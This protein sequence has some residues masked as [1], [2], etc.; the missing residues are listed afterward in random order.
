MPRRKTTEIPGLRNRLR[1]AF[2]AIADL[3]G[4]TQAQIAGDLGIGRTAITAIL[5]GT[6]K[7]PSRQTLMLLESVFGYRQEWLLTGQGEPQVYY[8]EETLFQNGIVFYR[9]GFQRRF[10]AN[11]EGRHRILAQWL[12]AVVQYDGEGGPWYHAAWDAK[13]VAEPTGEL[14]SF[15]VGIAAAEQPG[16]FVLVLR[17]PE[18]LLHLVVA[19]EPEETP[20]PWL[21]GEKIDRLLYV[22]GLFDGAWRQIPLRLGARV[23]SLP[24]L[25]VN[26]REYKQMLKGPYPKG[27]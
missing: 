13:D 17:Q 20:I 16:H 24:A 2:R 4:K 8:G 5:N 11:R 18:A 10:Y 12:H 6:T 9:L 3:T 25:G 1:C 27:R 7:S 26:E 14:C 22:T 21:H 23:S 15:P 19:N